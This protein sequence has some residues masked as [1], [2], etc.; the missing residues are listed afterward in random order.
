MNAVVKNLL[1]EVQVKSY[2]LAPLFDKYLKEN[3]I[4]YQVYPQPG[5]P[6]HTNKPRIN[7]LRRNRSKR[8]VPPIRRVGSPELETKTR[9]KESPSRALSLQGVVY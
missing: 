1:K 4:N 2:F 5:H 6:G 8:P 9:I 3:P 7:F